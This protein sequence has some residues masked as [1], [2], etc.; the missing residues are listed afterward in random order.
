MQAK[1]RNMGKFFRTVTVWLAIYGVALLA[2]T[3]LPGAGDPAAAPGVV[4]GL[5]MANSP[6]QSADG[7]ISTVVRTLKPM[8]IS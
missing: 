7:A 6:Y 4:Y 3:A 8:V 1:T 2:L 5:G